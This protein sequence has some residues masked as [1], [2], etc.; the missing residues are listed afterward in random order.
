MK[1]SGELRDIDVD[2]YWG[3]KQEN[4]FPLKLGANKQVNLRLYFIRR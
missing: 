2:V 3:D 4:E 1:N